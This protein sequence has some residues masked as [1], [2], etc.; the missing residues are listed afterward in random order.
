MK[1]VLIIGYLE[2]YC[3]YRGGSPRTLGLAN[4]LIEFGWQPIVLTAPL[5]GKPDFGAKVKIIETPYRDMFYHLKKLLRWFGISSDRSVSEQL[6]EKIGVTSKK[7]F[8]DFLLNSYMAIFAYPDTEKYWKSFAIKETDKLLEKEKIDAVISIWPITAHLVAK[9]LKD[10]YKIPWI[11]DFTHLWSQ[12]YYYKYGPIRKLFDKKLEIK[13]ILKADALT[14]VSD[15]FIG[16][17]KELHKRQFIHF[18]PH[19]FDPSWLQTAPP[20]LTTKFTITYTGHIYPEKQRVS[21]FFIAIK[22]LIDE[23]LLNPEEV[24]IRFYGEEGDWLK[25]EIE[26]YKLSEIIHQYGPIPH[27]VSLQ[28]QHE[29]QILLHLGWDDKNIKGFY[30]SKIFEYL[31][32]QRPILGVGGASDGVVEKLLSETKAGVYGKEILEV[33]NFIKAFYDEYK[34]QGKITYQGDIKKINKYSHRKMAK[35]FADILNRLI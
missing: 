21:K 26:K 6:K 22:E 30:T 33:K 23:N 24:E 25:K 35:K 31:A 5:R 2:P 3:L 28:K 8:I 32:A 1:K 7:S 27:R 19:G 16:K 12:G 13:T 4:Y 18:I 11:A 29:S 34:F 20:S 14:T 17:L 9:E 15:Y 10:K